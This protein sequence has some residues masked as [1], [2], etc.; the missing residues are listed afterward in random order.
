MK[1]IVRV[2]AHVSFNRKKLKDKACVKILKEEFKHSNPVFH[3]NEKM[4]I[5]N[6][7]N[8]NG[9]EVIVQPKFY[10]S[11]FLRG[12][13]IY[14]SRGCLKEVKRTLNSFGHTVKIK[15]KRV[16][17]DKVEFNSKIKLRTEQKPA[18]ET[19][20]VKQQG[21]IRGP[22]SSG[23]SVIGLEIIARSG[24]VGMVIVWSKVHQEQWIKEAMRS[25]LLNLKEEDIGG[26]GGKFAK[27]K[28][29]KLN[30]CM[31]QSLWNEEHRKFFFPKCGV[32][33][34]DEVQRYA[35][36]TFNSVINDSPAKIRIGLSANEK[37]KDKKEFLIYDAF[38]K[39]INII[40]DSN[41][42]SRKK[43]RINLVT[44]KY[45]N[46]EYE[47]TRNSPE[48]LNDMARS[49]SRNKII[50]R[51]LKKKTSKKK[52]VLILVERKYQAL[53]LRQQIKKMDLKVRLMVG[54]FSKAEIENADDWKSSWRKFAKNYNDDEEFYKLV[55]LGTKKK[56]DV[57]VATQ[58]GDVGLNIKTI[59]H[60]I[61]ATP[62]G[63]NLERFNQQKGR[64]ERDHDEKLEKIFGKKPT[65]TVD[66][67]WDIKI[68][69][70][71]SKGENIMK[72]FTNVHVITKG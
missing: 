48:L 12:K 16:D 36:N 49:I 32:L 25:D 38:G 27:R 2:D 9:E 30:I 3:K 1:V 35:A 57:I 61:I 11:Y 52:L 64:A 13:R 7:K 22:C 19:A 10:K 72:N 20:L 67:I 44:T 26:V 54:N 6:T 43:A 24:R 40:D 31:Q 65:P 63:G 45:T 33:I 62:T 58:K 28:I 8:K 59:D 4:G 56:I 34:A 70:L 39:I 69:S 51:R 37:R 47:F 53:Y 14:F 18:V 29:G 21:I 15:K 5:P 50:L 66:Y 68:E 46:D 23:K 41:I 17:G 42:G 60:V 71:R 55:E